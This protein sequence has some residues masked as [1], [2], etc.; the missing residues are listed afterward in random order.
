VSIPDP[1]AV[2][3]IRAIGWVLVSPLLAGAARLD[4]CATDVSR[5]TNLRRAF[6]LPA[7]QTEKH[8]QAHAPRGNR[9]LNARKL[10]ND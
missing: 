9:P 1:A 2:H 10:I 3:I 8:E 6:A 4:S 5:V 7:S